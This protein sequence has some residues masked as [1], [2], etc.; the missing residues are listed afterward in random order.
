MPSDSLVA[1]RI[2]VPDT[3]GADLFNTTPGSASY[4]QGRPPWLASK[5]RMCV[6]TNLVDL[7]VVLELRRNESAQVSRPATAR[8]EALLSA[9]SECLLCP[10]TTNLNDEVVGTAIDHRDNTIRYS[11]PE[12]SPTLPATEKV[13]RLFSHDSRPF[14]A[15]EACGRPKTRCL[16][17][18]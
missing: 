17:S 10:L 13:V 4:P 8:P 14:Q 1:L 16:V 3:S 2:F 5:L 9:T 6:V 15:G 7:D 18:A 12:Y 11:D